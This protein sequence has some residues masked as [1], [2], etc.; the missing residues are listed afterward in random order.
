MQKEIISLYAH[1]TGYSIVKLVK[2]ERWT[3]EKLVWGNPSYSKIESDLQSLYRGIGKILINS[4][5][6]L[7]GK[8]KGNYRFT[9]VNLSVSENRENFNAKLFHLIASVNDKLIAFNSQ[10][11]NSVEL[12]E[13]IRFYSV[14]NHSNDLN[15]LI[16]AVDSLKLWELRNPILGT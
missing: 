14:D 4:D 10:D 9:L 11:K 12:V 8:L 5:I 6:E 2:K 15:S 13:K 3:V 1:F 16:M 7:N